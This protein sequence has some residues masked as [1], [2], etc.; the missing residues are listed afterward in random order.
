M[1]ICMILFLGIDPLFFLIFG[2]QAGKE[3]E[4]FWYMPL[5]AAAFFIL[6]AWAFLDLGNFSFLR[7]ALMYSFM[8]I[9]SMLMTRFFHYLKIMAQQEK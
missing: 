1:T 3:I 5:V 2:Y 4:K 9:L 8:G 6:G 7:Y